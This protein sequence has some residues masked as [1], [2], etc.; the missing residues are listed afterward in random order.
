MYLHISDV[1]DNVVSTV[2]IDVVMVTTLFYN[3][4]IDKVS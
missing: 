1:V 2:L 3:V 4:R